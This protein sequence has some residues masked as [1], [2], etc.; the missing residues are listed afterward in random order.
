MSVYFFRVSFVTHRKIIQLSG[1][2]SYFSVGIFWNRQNNWIFSVCSKK[3][4]EK[5]VTH[6]AIQ[7]SSSVSGIKHL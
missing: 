5:L 7:V 3:R 1:E 2:F 6:R 4:T